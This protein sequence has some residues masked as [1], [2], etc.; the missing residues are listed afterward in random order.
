MSYYAEASDA[1]LMATIDA[2]SNKD[3][4]V[5]GKSHVPGCTLDFDGYC[6][7]CHADACN[8]LDEMKRRRGVT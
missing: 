7:D 1:D 4:T 8:A 5:P 6:L 2:W 3:W